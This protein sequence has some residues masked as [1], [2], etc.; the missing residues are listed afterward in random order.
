M[1]RFFIQDMGK[2]SVLTVLSIV[3]LLAIAIFVINSPSGSEGGLVGAFYYVWWHDGEGGR[4]WWNEEVMSDIPLLGLYDSRNQSVISQHISWANQYGIDFFCVSWW[5]E[6][7]WEDVTLK[8]YFLN[9]DNISNIQF[10]ILYE[11]YDLL[12]VEEESINFDGNNKQKLVDDFEYL[13]ETYFGHTQYLKIDEKPVV[14]IYNARLFNVDYEDAIF[15]LRFKMA[16]E[17]YDLYLIGD[18]VSWLPSLISANLAGQ[19]DA[20]SCYNMVAP[21]PDISTNFVEKVVGKY[22]EWYLTTKVPLGV[23][24]IPSVIPSFVE[25][26][27]EATTP[28]VELSLDDFRLFCENVKTYSDVP[29][30][31][32]ICSFNE[33]YEGTQIE[34]SDISRD[35]RLDVIFEYFG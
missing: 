3:I 2:G 9:N 32:L 6:G 35:D 14:F 7:S 31:T 11:S 34:K 21:L 16:E 24:F 20:I 22:S 17:G 30:G 8:D 18:M 19:F 13:A 4:N 33:W 10:A 15:E 23:D 1:S 29:I 5:G 26:N 12:E 28:V 25:V 27:P